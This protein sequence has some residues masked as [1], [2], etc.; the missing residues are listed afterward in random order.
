[1]NLSRAVSSIVSSSLSPVRKIADARASRSTGG[2]RCDLTILLKF[3]RETVPGK[4]PVDPRSKL[5][6]PS[7]SVELQMMVTEVR[8]KAPLNRR[9]HSTSA[10]LYQVENGQGRRLRTRIQRPLDFGNL[11]PKGKRHCMLIGPHYPSAVRAFGRK[12]RSEAAARD[13]TAYDGNDPAQA[14]EVISSPVRG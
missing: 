12:H 1:M 7:I 13:E 6:T 3:K 2:P 14:A 9:C 5:G 8:M 10:E 11:C 4:E